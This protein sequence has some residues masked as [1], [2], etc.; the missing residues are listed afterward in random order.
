[1]SDQPPPPPPPS[2][3]TPPPEQPDYGTGP[4]TP[5]TPEP[6]QGPSQPYQPPRQPV[7][8]GYQPG[9][10]PPQGRPTNGLAITSLISGI[11][12][13]TFFPILGSI[14]ALV[15]GYLGK[16]Q[17][18]RSQGAQDG[19]GMAIA[20]IVLGWIGVVLTLLITA[21]IVVGIFAAVNSGVTEGVGGEIVD[22]FEQGINEGLLDAVDES[23][24]GCTPVETYP[25]MGAA[26]IDPS[27]ASSV[28]YNSD[29]PTSGPHFAVPAEPGFYTTPVESPTLVHN[30]EHGQIVIWYS[31]DADERIVDQL[32]FLTAQE[33]VATVAT[34]YDNV[35]EDATFVLTA[36]RHSRA[37]ALPSQGVFDDFRRQ[38]QGEGP[39]PITPPFEG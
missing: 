28:V 6:Y 32:E 36:W 11:A 27:E 29:P 13:L 14:L 25:D 9:Y 2:G 12:G 20:G 38:F 19:R 34:P 8:E 17:I 26:H 23:A 16:G 33:P 24:A 10:Y 4:F 15:F 1:M 37:C 21:L 22:E 30:L 7:Q 39:E 3:P 5:P 31:P 18:D 35:P